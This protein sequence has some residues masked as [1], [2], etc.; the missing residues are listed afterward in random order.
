MKILVTGAGGFLGYHICERLLKEGHEVFNFSRSHHTDLDKLNVKTIKGNLQNSKDVTNA[1]KG[2]EA[3]FH[4]A[5][6]VAMWGKWEDFYNTNVVGTENIINACKEHGIKT[7]VYTSTPSVVFGTKDIIN[8]NEEIPYPTDFKSLYAKSKSIAEKK[9][10]CANKENELHTCALRPHLIFGPR[11]KNIIPRL[12]DAA[13]KG[14]LKRIGDGNNLVDVIHVENAA[15]AHINAFKSLITDKKAQG[16]AYFIAQEKPVNLWDFIN[17][18][19]TKFNEKPIEK[20]I[21][22]K[23]AYRIGAIIEFFLKLFKVYD[24]HP[25]MTRFVAMQMSKSH[26]FSHDNAEKDFGYSP[27]LNLEEAIDSLA[28]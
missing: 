3:V 1:L 20:K 7:L 18:I 10:L 8:G 21:S 16:K 9:V 26:Y 19:L 12:V 13:K 11:D 24:V 6:K 27:E 28:T 5:S 23:K 22:F 4:V 2:F 14:R 15:A 25:P 17:T